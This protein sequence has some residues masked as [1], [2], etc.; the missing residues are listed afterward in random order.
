MAALFILTPALLLPALLLLE[1]FER[2]ALRGRRRDDDAT[3][4]MPAYD[5][6]SRH[7]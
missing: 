1:R 4:T 6:W 7:E 2:Y 5:E 3:G